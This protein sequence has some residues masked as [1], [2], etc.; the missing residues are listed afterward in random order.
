MKSF[1]GDPKTQTAQRDT[2]SNSKEIQ[3][4]ERNLL[5]RREPQTLVHIQPKD[6]TE[7]VRKPT[8]EEGGD[9]AEQVTEHRYRGGN[10]PRHDP[11]CEGNTNPRSRRDPVALVHAVC[12]LENTQVD[13]FE[14]D[15]TV[16]HTG[17]DDGRQ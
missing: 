14:R 4:S 8:G 1:P 9:Q 17:D 11:Q 3:Q 16:D 15:V 6:A 13:V 12:S 7:A 2:N 5:R 10:N